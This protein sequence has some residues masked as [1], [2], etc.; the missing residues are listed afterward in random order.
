VLYIL[1]NLVSYERVFSTLNQL[2]TKTRNTLTP[3]R[4]DKLLYIQINSRTLRRDALVKELSKD[5]NEEEEDNL[6]VDGDE[7]AIF[8]RPAHIKEVLLGPDNLAEDSRDKFI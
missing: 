5:E 2:Y 6:V 1:I 7:D 8:V 3:E 4:V